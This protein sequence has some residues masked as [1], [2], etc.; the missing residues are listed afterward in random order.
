[1]NFNKTLTKHL[2]AMSNKQFD[3]FISTVCSEKI[4]LIMPNGTLISKYEDF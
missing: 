3:A 4:T 2:D 1:M